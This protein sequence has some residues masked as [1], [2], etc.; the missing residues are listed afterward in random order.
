MSMF[1]N[2][3]DDTIS[4]G[5]QSMYSN[6]VAQFSSTSDD[7]FIRLFTNNNTRALGNDNL[8]SGYAIGSSNFDKTQTENNSLYLGYITQYSNITKV[9]NIQNNS[10]GINTI[11]P[12]ATLEVYT[13]RCCRF[14]L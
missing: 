7:V 4:F 2:N 14:R 8:K 11:N 12:Q 6:E 10:V 3:I 13:S 9:L 1:F 5:V